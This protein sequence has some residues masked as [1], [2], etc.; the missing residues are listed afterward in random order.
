MKKLLLFIVSCLLLSSCSSLIE[1]ALERKGI[2]DEK[3]KLDILSNEDKK[4]VII[5][6]HHIG[7]QSFYDDVRFKVDSLRNL[8]FDFLYETIKYDSDFPKEQQ[9]LYDMKFRKF[10]GLHIGKEGYFD[11]ITNKIAGRVKVDKEHKLVNQPR[12]H[13]LGVDSLIDTKAD[14]PKNIL[15]DKFETKYGVIE[16]EE[17]DYNTPLGETYKC[18]IWKKRDKNR[19]EMNNYLIQDIRNE[20]IVN[21][22]VNSKNNN[23]AVIYGKNHIEGVTKLLQKQDSTWVKINTN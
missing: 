19:S 4:I 8:G 6:M 23:I 16:L 17:C 3:A 13:K 9:N 1:M 12:Y 15:I 7:K 22:I 21:K 2:F 5:G 11:T 20:E 18:T 10:L 14:L